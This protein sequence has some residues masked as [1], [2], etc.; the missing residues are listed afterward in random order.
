VGAERFRGIQCVAYC[1]IVFIVRCMFSSLSVVVGVC[2][3][4]PVRYCQTPTTVEERH[5][6]CESIEWVSGVM[7]FVMHASVLIGCCLPPHKSFPALCSLGDVLTVL[8][9]TNFIWKLLVAF[10]SHVTLTP[11]CR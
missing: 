11:V 7:K 4:V 3:A 9:V 1:I 5:V 8:F 10:G 2:L 6:C